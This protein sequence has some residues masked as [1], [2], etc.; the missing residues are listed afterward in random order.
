MSR[1]RTGGPLPLRARPAG[2]AGISLVEV[3]VSLSVLGVFM[4]VF[5]AGVLQVYRA[6]DTTEAVASAQ[7][8]LHVAFQR[9]DK[10]IRYASWIS[11]PSRPI[12]GRRYVEFAAKDPVT[13]EETRCGQLLLDLDRG[14]LQLRRWEA[15]S[16]P[17]ERAPGETLASYIATDGLAAEPPSGGAEPP[18]TLQKAGSTPDRGN[19][20]A[21]GADFAPDFQRLELHLTA[22]VGTGEK[23]GA[24]N[25]DVSFT[26]LNTS[27]D[28]PATHKCSEG[29][30]S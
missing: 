2:D 8:Q 11:E 12:R 21:V 28:T 5:T 24:A 6:V 9:L 14:V 26:A 30:P 1:T 22:R 15:G 18:F 17:A 20:S 13:K 4:A 16:P 23:S 19:G 3:M 29:R 7:S 25:L 27:R 10:E